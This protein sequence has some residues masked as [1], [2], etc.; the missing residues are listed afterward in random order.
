M[1]EH[2]NVNTLSAFRHLFWTHQLQPALI[3]GAKS[4]GT[5]IPRSSAASPSR[6][7]VQQHEEEIYVGEVLDGKRQGMGI[8]LGKVGGCMRRSFHGGNGL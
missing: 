8:L 3:R 6:W 2:F 1:F 5:A 4:T 7:Q